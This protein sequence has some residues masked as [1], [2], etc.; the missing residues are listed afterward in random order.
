VLCQQLI[1]KKIYRGA[2]AAA[3]MQKTGSYHFNTARNGGIKKNR[4]VPEHQQKRER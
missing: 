4:L 1:L 3:T 2:G